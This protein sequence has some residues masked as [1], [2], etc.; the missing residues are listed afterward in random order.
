MEY[1]PSD[2]NKM[3]IFQ[4]K[5]ANELVKMVNNG[6]SEG[7]LPSSTLKEMSSHFIN[8]WAFKPRYGHFKPPKTSE[9][10]IPPNFEGSKT[11]L[12]NNIY[13]DSSN[14]SS[15]TGKRSREGSK[16]L[17]FEQLQKYFAVA[18][19]KCPYAV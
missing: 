5:S 6:K 13:W 7:P 15:Y 3:P 14:L 1:L 19:P 17:Y 10:L 2:I 18:Q 16:Y 12:K 8:F 11:H 9:I 4:Q